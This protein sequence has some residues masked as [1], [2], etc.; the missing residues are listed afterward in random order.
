MK[1]I[2]QRLSA[3]R[4]R[5]TDGDDAVSTGDVNRAVILIDTYASDLPDRANLA[6]WSITET[7]IV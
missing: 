2:G 5:R 1:G 6:R 7:T 4:S 3:R